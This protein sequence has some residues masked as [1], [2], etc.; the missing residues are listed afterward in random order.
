MT[1]RLT[2]DGTPVEARPGATVLEAAREADVEIPTLCY[3]EGTPPQTSCFLCAVRVAGY[4]SLQPACALKAREGMVVEAHSEEVVAARRTALELLFSDH[5]GRCVAPCAMACPAHLDVPGFLDHLAAGRLD[6]AAAVVRRQLVL[7]AVLGRVCPAYCQNA[8]VLAEPG[9]PISIRTLHSWL[10]ER[11]LASGKPAL[12]QPPPPSGKRVAIVGAGPAG[13]AAA[14]E[15]ACRGHAAH[16]VEAADAPGGLLRLLPAEVLD[17]NVLQ[18]EIAT[19]EQMGA[20]L[21]Y[22]WRLGTDSTLEDLRRESD[23]VVLACGTGVHTADDEVR[24]DA[25]NPRAAGRMPARRKTPPDLALFESCGLNVSKNGIAAD[26]RT[27]LTNLEGVF[28]AGECVSGPSAAIRA[29]AAGRQVAVAADQYLR[30][31]SVTGPPKPFYFQRVSKTEDPAPA[32]LAGMEPKT[33]EQAPAPID[34]VEPR[35]IEE[36]AQVPAD[37]PDGVDVPAARAEASRCLQCTCAEAETCRLRQYAARYAARPYRFKGESRALDPDESH[38]EIV[39]EPGKCILCGICLRIARE[40]GENPGLS[41]A[42]RGFST[43]VAVPF[44]GKIRDGL[45]KAPRPCAEACPTAA[46]HLKRPEQEA[47]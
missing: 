8:C 27:S 42:G 46:L 7:P 47:P 39:Y 24:D 23:A 20:Q 29:I 38:A 16:L 31:E 2:I 34:G 4:E 25:P 11:E 22:G 14:F 12:P 26:R 19:I 33:N 41:F 15:L 43:R 30:R 3:L 17:P 44:D 36:T 6:Q 35:A 10:A 37:T 5:A 45:A 21:H 40:G 18:A 13:L 32:A 1:I 28:A 9:E